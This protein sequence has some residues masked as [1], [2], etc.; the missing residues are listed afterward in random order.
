M[1]DLTYRGPENDQALLQWLDPATW[2]DLQEGWDRIH[3]ELSRID[4]L[5]DTLERFA[6]GREK[7]ELRRIQEGWE[8]E[9]FPP[10]W[11][12]IIDLDQFP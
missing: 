12:G 9:G 5:G 2:Q 1:N 3:V 10:P 11:D 6:R 7:Q 4:M 8:R